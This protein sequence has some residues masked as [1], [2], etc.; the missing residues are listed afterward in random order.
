MRRGRVVAALVL[1]PALAIGGWWFFGR[2]SADSL[3]AGSAE[4][5]V[6]WRGTYQGAMSLP[7]TLNW[8]P[9]TRVGVLE[10]MAGDSGVALILYERD[11]LTSGPHAIMSPDMAPSAAKPGASFVMRWLRTKPDT[12]VTGFRSESG[13]ARIQIAGGKA[14]GDINARMRGATGPDTLVVQGGFS[15]V[16]IV[17]TAKGCT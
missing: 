3:R 13:T 7:A 6:R 14:S 11:S 12:A 9:V 15:G 10:A 5:S 16:S 8:C 1:V 17:T 4:L 2:S